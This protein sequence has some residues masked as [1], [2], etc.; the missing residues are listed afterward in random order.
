[1]KNFKNLIVSVN[2]F[3]IGEIFEQLKQVLKELP[4]KI[5]NFPKIGKRILD[6]IK[7]YSTMPPVV[8]KIKDVVERVRNLFLDIK[9]DV[10]E[11]YEVTMY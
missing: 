6:V 2:N 1:M 10:T 8:K 11:F 3:D 5:L 4:K 9:N 7:R